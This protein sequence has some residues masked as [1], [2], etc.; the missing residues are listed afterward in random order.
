MATHESLHGTPPAILPYYGGSHEDFNAFGANNRA[1]YVPCWIPVAVTLTGIRLRVGTQSGNICVG[2]YNSA[3]SR[4][5]TSGAVSCP[6]T[7]VQ[8]VNFTGN[9]AATAGTYYLALSCDNT[10]ATFSTTGSG[11]GMPASCRYQETAHPLP[12]TA[13]FAGDTSLTLNLV[14]R[15]NG[16]FP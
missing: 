14:G 16:G 11:V 13:T 10:T 15:V 2:L 4:V 7:G 1:T 5:A 12:S 9:Y 8:A 6:A 3:G